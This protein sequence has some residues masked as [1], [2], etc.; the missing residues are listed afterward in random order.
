M[1]ERHSSLTSPPDPHEMLPI[2][3]ET[4]RHR[5]EE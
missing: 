2:P 3:N 5:E 1:F 4:I